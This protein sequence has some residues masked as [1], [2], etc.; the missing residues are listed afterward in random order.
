MLDITSGG[1]HTL[2]DN[3]FLDV[4]ING[5]YPNV[6][7]KMSN[8]NTYECNYFDGGYQGI[9]FDGPNAATYFKRTTFDD[10]DESLILVDGEIG[11]QPPEE[12]EEDYYGNTW[13]GNNN[14]GKI[15][16]GSGSTPD[17]IAEKSQFTI[18]P[19]DLPVSGLLQPPSYDPA[20]I[21][22]IWF[23]P[24]DEKD[25]EFCE[26]VSPWVEKDKDICELDEKPWWMSLDCQ[27]LQ[28]YLD[29]VLFTSFSSPNMDHYLWSKQRYVLKELLNYPDLRD[30]CSYVDSLWSG[31]IGKSVLD[32]VYVDSLWGRLHFPDGVDCD[33]ITIVEDSIRIFVE[34]L[35]ELDSLLVKDTINTE[36]ELNQKLIKLHQLDSISSVWMDMKE[37]IAVFHKDKLG[38]L[39]S[40]IDRLIADSLYEI[41][42]KRYWQLAMEKMTN[43]KDTL[44]QGEWLELAQLAQLCPLEAGVGVYGARSLY[45]QYD[46][47]VNYDDLQLCNMSPPSPLPLEIVETNFEVQVKIAPNP[48]L[49]T[50]VFSMFNPNKKQISFD[51][52]NLE[53]RVLESYDFGTV[54]EIEKTIGLTIE[55]AG[56]YIARISIDGKAYIS[57]KLIKLDK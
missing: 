50:F 51:L 31:F 27:K 28:Y 21:G 7:S 48:S 22:A 44:S 8:G 32:Y 9:R 30:S 42:L 33:S 47:T 19:F 13:I 1:R 54:K 4:Y 53:G 14:V 52:F 25:N 56:L 37:S 26:P 15:I 45:N 2:I 55:K 35:R 16:A 10:C 20:N 34:E 46:P 36:V 38:A 40:E 24:D 5:S 23:K 3:D 41:T 11:P 17:E 29:S 39:S 49:E 57:N 18:N 43:G 12:I 6:N